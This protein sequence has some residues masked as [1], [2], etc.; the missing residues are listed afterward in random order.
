MVINLD[1]SREDAIAPQHLFADLVD[2][3]GSAVYRFCLN[4]TSSDEDADDLFQ[5]TFLKAAELLPKLSKSDNPKR[6]LFA[7]AANLRKKHVTKYARRSRLAPTEPL[8]DTIA[9]DVDLERAAAEQ[10]EFRTVFKLVEEL[11]EK[12]KI[13][14]LMYYAWEMSVQEIAE[15]LEIPGGTVKSRLHKSRK[16]VEKGLVKH[17]YGT[18]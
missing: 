18:D 16:I 15:A 14:T 8:S 10:E 6:F 12:L 9:S 3:H 2:K 4:L 5:E 13:P 7:T 11:P 1:K 17:G